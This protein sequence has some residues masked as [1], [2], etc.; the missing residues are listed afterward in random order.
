[1]P[2]S[3]TA[4]IAQ[5]IADIFND[6]VTLASEFR[7]LS[8][9]DPIRVVQLLWN[10]GYIIVQSVI[11]ALFKP[12]TPK[13]KLSK[14][15]GRIAV[16]GAGLTGVSS[17]AHAISHNFEVVIYEANPRKKLGGI[18]A[19]VNRTSGLQLNSLLYRFHP[20]IL[21]SRAFP[22]RDEI[23]GEI[24]RVWKDYDLESRTKFNTRVTSVRR[25]PD[26]DEKNAERGMPRWIVNDGEDG[27][28][29]AIIVTVGTCGK[30][31]WVKLP[32]MP[33]DVGKEEEEP[34]KDDEPSQDVDLP[35]A[36]GPVLFA[37]VVK[38][39]Q[40]IN[41][42]EDHDEDAN[43]DD[44]KRNGRNREDPESP[45]LYSQ[46]VKE[47]HHEG[48][49][50]QANGKNGKNGTSN[51]IFKKPIIHS[52]QL[53]STEAAN[54]EGKRIVVIGSGAS[55][56]EAVETA[57]ARCGKD[58]KV[59]MVA[60]S[61]KW[62]IPRN[63]MIDTF[64]ACQP[65]GR[66]MPLSFLWEGFLK[67]WHYHGAKDLVPADRGIF[68]GTP[69]VNDEFIPHVRAGRCVYVRG[70]PV[71][72]TS[73][74]VVVNQ[75][76]RGSKPKDE[77]EETLL[78]ADIV[79]LAT[80]FEKPDIDFLDKSLFPEGYERPNLYLQNFSTEDWSILTTNSAY[81]NAIGTVGHFHIGIYT[82]ILLVLLMD[83]SARPTPKDMKLWVDVVRFIKRG[84]EG[85]ALGF[86]TYAELTIW[87]LGF[88]LLRPDRLRW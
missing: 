49:L 50:P 25:A 80:G 46:V 26:D 77:G 47:G 13:R 88:H 55:G 78:E 43:H 63:I 61:D 9:L 76:P 23:L 70:D 48:P 18:W 21:W 40:P 30:P 29:N 2:A 57:L 14:P 37:D 11:I 72:L 56:V 82:R 1:M 12:P 4:A 59:W 87:L 51:D 24:T 28:F 3:A 67:H 85:G 73:K 62:I 10:I 86:F 74:G 45:M 33:E 68:E 53:D 83:Q 71:R 17:A 38:G 75:R 20:A 34:T 31:K 54:L 36:A 52:S 79:V 69:V 58:G 64:L 7:I 42:D 8:L 60:R 65:F 66:Q 84:A 15:H 5:D 16:I 32:G 41:S 19:H 35:S 6:S 44:E 39:E 81:Q 22:A 27:V